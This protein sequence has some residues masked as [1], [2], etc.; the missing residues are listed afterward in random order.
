MLGRP[1]RS[2][3][4]ASQRR[5]LGAAAR[6]RSAHESAFSNS[7]ASSRALAQS[8]VLRERR[9]NFR[10]SVP[11]AKIRQ[12]QRFQSRFAPRTRPSGSQ[13]RGPLRRLPG[14]AG[15]D[16]APQ[17]HSSSIARHCPL[18]RPN[19]RKLLILIWRRGWDSNPRALADKTLSRRARYDHF[20]TSP[21]GRTASGC[22]E[23]LIIARLSRRIH[24]GG[25]TGRARSPVGRR[26]RAPPGATAA[27]A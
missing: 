18:E 21:L 1:P 11:E 23:P 6:G 9:E 19:R 2:L 20:G 16:S 14:A 10:P 7:P 26:L 5:A 27:I 24:T 12:P 15:R 22:P 4:A 17:R 3:R 25:D 8:S 13:T